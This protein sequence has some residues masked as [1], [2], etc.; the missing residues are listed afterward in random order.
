MMRP[1]RSIGRLIRGEDGKP[2]LGA[3]FGQ[4]VLLKLLAAMQQIVLAPPR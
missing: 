3:F 2:A 1:N 4:E